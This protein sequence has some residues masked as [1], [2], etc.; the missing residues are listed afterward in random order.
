MIQNQKYI[1]THLNKCKHN[2]KNKKTG[3][4]F[5]CT[6]EDLTVYDPQLSS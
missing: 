2:K 4:E 5:R 6:G 1:V 3:G